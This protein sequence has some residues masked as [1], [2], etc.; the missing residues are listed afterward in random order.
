VDDVVKA[1][2]DLS[3]HSHALGEIFNVGNS[4]SISINEL[5]E[6]I[7]AMANSS[8]KIVHI[9]YEKAYEKGFE[10]MKYRQP[11]ITKIKE[12][13]SFKPKVGIDEMLEKIIKD[14]EK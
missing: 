5:A 14:F 12:L 2:R 3:R 8:S 7:R 6:K 11:N 9:P 13:I 1:I 10:D 4:K